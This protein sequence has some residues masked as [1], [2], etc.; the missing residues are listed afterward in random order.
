[1]GL[2]MNRAS[3]P[4]RWTVYGL[5]ESPFFQ[6]SLGEGQHPRSLSLFVGRETEL[7]D[8]LAGIGGGSSSRRTLS[9]PP[10]IGKTTLVQAAKARANEAGYWAGEDRVSVLAG[11]DASALTGRILGALYDTVVAKRPQGDAP[12]LEKIR[13]YV[14]AFRLERGGASIAGFGAER[15]TEVST[16]SNLMYEA[17]QLI[18]E[19][20]DYVKRS[21][22]L[23]MILHLNNLENL[24]DAEL[25]VAADVL[26]SLRDIVFM[27]DHLH[28]LVVGTDDSIHGTIGRHSQLASVFGRTSVE[29]LPTEDVLRLLQRRYDALASKAR[30]FVP[31]VTEDAVAA[32]YA[33]CSGDL[34]SLL[35]ALE[36]GVT[37][38][39]GLTD[40]PGASLTLEELAPVL[41]VRYHDE[42]RRELTEKRASQLALWG[43][44]HPDQPVTQ[45][46]LTDLWA[47][48]QAAV[49][50][51]LKSLAPVWVRR[52]EG[53]GTIRNVL[54]GRARIAFGPVIG[55]AT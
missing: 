35:R 42:A 21:G 14:R 32:L 49:S 10:G 37:A 18:R 44:A 8:F 55:P 41:K 1:M 31:P 6:D 34:R 39:T 24:A 28:V 16:P 52:V 36:D 47:V 54:S 43:Q 22:S 20:L 7:D 11:D 51:A 45:Q 4:N 26:R 40:P 53:A 19:L 38:L 12:V 3:L 15:S 5:S 23:G 17:P 25:A 46:Q 2:L 29:P 27:Q 33:T 9:G 13:Q 30:P 48:S 50:S